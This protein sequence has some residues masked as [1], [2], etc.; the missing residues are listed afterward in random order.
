LVQ[1]TNG[2]SMAEVAAIGHM[3]ILI[4]TD[5]GGPVS[6]LAARNEINSTSSMPEPEVRPIGYV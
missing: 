6:L 2:W 1:A 4:S 3:A 5:T